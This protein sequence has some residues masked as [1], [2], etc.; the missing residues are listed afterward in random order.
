MPDQCET[1][2]MEVIDMNYSTVTLVLTEF[3][4]ERLRQTARQNIRRP[5]DQAR[6]IL[7]S[8]LGLT[9]E[10]NTPIPATIIQDGE[11]QHA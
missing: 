11:L 7:L 4:M 3:E 5:R 8:G 6:Y 10:A 2:N 9:D 1:I